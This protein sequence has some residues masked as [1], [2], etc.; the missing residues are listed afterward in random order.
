MA[1]ARE[2]KHCYTLYASVAASGINVMKASMDEKLN[3]VFTLKNSVDRA[4]YIITFTAISSPTAA[5][6]LTIS[7]KY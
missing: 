5:G 3:L 1:V 7:G 2:I 6:N 4:R